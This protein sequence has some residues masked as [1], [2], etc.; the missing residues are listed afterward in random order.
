[1][2][3]AR[4]A[5]LLLVFSLLVSPMSAHARGG[6]YGGV[7]HSSAF[8]PTEFREPWMDGMGYA[9]G[10]EQSLGGRLSAVFD[11]TKS[12]FVPDAGFFSDGG[13]NIVI[14]GVASSFLVSGGAK[15][16]LSAGTGRVSP[17]LQGGAG[18]SRLSFEPLD[19]VHLFEGMM[20]SYSGSSETR[21]AFRAGGGLLVHGPA[22]SRLDAQ[23]DYQTVLL[24]GNPAMLYGTARMLILFRLN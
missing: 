21:G 14:G 17:F 15:Y 3:L 22:G 23:F 24:P 12:R 9:A 1:M 11:V 10:L 16:L 13:R 2:P 8:S 4:I 5:F 18:L 7:S 20:T 6:A 19:L